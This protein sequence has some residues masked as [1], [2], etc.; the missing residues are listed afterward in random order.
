MIYIIKLPK[1]TIINV[2]RLN[3]NEFEFKKRH[4][5]IIDKQFVNITNHLISSFKK[6]KFLLSF[7][8]M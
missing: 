5:Q 1:R 3:K 2:Q 4:L 8:S 7:K 6:N